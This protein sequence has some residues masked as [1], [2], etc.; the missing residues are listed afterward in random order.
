MSAALNEQNRTLKLKIKIR[1]EELNFE[2]VYS[3][4]TNIPEGDFWIVIPAGEIP[5]GC[6]E[7]VVNDAYGYK[8]C[9]RHQYI[10]TDF[11]ELSEAFVEIDG[12]RVCDVHDLQVD[13]ECL[14][15][16]GELKEELNRMA[17]DLKSTTS[18]N[19]AL[20][21]ETMAVAQVGANIVASLER[22][23]EQGR[24]IKPD[25]NPWTA[26]QVHKALKDLKDN[27]F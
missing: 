14:I 20:A 24:V 27:A 25:R 7:F 9:V 5:G 6:V 17:E 12:R 23:A 2:G 1:S 21:L 13:V 19:M 15:S 8:A 26:K 10:T 22:W 3:F 4:K 11:P 18:P 16:F